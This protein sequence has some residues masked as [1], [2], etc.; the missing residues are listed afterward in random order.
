MRVAHQ[1]THSPGPYFVV[2]MVARHNIYH[3]LVYIVAEQEGLHRDL[4]HWVGQ[5]EVEEVKMHSYN[6]D[7]GIQLRELSRGVRG[8]TMLEA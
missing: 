5:V 6:L 1:E 3:H 4:E 8:A 7:A 2:G